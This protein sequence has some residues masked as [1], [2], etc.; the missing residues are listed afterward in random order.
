LEAGDVLLLEASPSF[1]HRQREARDFYLVSAVERGTVQRHERAWISLAI[2]I[3][4]VLAAALT[5]ISI[6]TAALVAAMTM[7]MLRCCT[8]NEARRSIDWSVLLVIGSAIGIGTALEQSGAASAIAGGLLNLAGENPHRSLAAIYLATMLCT[9]LITNNAAAVLMFSISVKAADSLGVNTA[10]FVIAVMIAASAS[11]LTPSG[12]QTNL[13]VY[14]AGGYRVTDYLRFGLP[15]SLV[16]F[17]VAMVVIP[18]YWP[19]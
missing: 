3:A 18:R 7:I 5:R 10:P 4:M 1:M 12:Y 2:M 13:M 15:L 14:G 11:F 17:A 8:A 9:E 6:L 16:V 19:F